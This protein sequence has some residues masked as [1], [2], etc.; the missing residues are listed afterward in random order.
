MLVP[1][2]KQQHETSRFRSNAAEQ[3]QPHR[4]FNHKVHPTQPQW[5]TSHYS[6]KSTVKRKKNF[7]RRERKS[8]HFL[9]SWWSLLAFGCIWMTLFYLQWQILAAPASQAHAI[10]FIR[11]P[12][13]FT[14]VPN[15]LSES[16]NPSTGI[17][18]WAAAVYATTQEKWAFILPLQSFT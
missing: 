5:P 9:S 15:A 10:S 6:F 7:K 12:G 2:S 14:W 1:F 17:M 3:P 13:A 11:F 4:F 18:W 8:S 16:Q